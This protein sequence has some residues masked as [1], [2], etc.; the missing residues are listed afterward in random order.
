MLPLVA[1]TSMQI[2]D[3]DTVSRGVLGAAALIEG[4][5]ID[6]ALAARLAGWDGDF[7]REVAGLDLVGIAG[8]AGARAVDPQ[9]RS[10]QQ[11]RLGNPVNR[12]I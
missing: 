11:E 7:S 2:G 1:S 9:L 10:G 5:R 12:I 4:G 8:L 3:I 6:A